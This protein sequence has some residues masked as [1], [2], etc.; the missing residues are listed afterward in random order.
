MDLQKNGSYRHTSILFSAHIA[1][2]ETVELPSRFGS[3]RTDS[4]CD[5]SVA[6]VLS[7]SALHPTT[8]SILSN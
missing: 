5:L 4:G 7:C 8:T 2:L 1:G 3:M 6:V